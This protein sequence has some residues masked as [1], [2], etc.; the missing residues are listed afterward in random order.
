M[1]RAYKWGDPGNGPAFILLLQKAVSLAYSQTQ[2]EAAAE[3]KISK[4][5]REV[6]KGGTI[7]SEGI[8]AGLVHMHT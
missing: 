2:Q 7:R 6:G 4:A 1:L 8:A 3:H 5:C